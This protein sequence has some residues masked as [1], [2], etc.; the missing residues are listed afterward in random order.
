MEGGLNILGAYS[1]SPLGTNVTVQPRVTTR[2]DHYGMTKSNLFVVAP[3]FIKL[4]SSPTRQKDNSSKTSC[5]MASSRQR[6]VCESVKLDRGLKLSL[7]LTPP[8]KHFCVQHHECH[9]GWDCRNLI[10]ITLGLK[11]INKTIK[12]RAS[13]L[14]SPQNRI[15]LCCR[16]GHSLNFHLFWKFSRR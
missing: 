9:P 7:V 6:A 8:Y 2:L 1:A 3:C 16:W 15:T 12:K 14:S 5:W 10:S 13:I 4:I 11:R